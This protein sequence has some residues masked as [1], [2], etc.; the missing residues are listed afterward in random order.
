MARELQFDREGRRRQA[1]AVVGRDTRIPRFMVG[2]IR[3]ELEFGEMFSQG[4]SVV[5]EESMQGPPGSGQEDVLNFVLGID[6]LI[7]TPIPM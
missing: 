5:N 4:A 6:S 7:G 3:R 1:G 2:Q